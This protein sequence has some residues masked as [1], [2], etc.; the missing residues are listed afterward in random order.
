[1]YTEREPDFE[2]NY[3]TYLFL[4]GKYAGKCID[5][6]HAIYDS[7][8]ILESIE[9]DFLLPITIVDDSNKY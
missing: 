3:V 5:M 8:A 7:R 2:G 6:N 4:N 9:N 1:M